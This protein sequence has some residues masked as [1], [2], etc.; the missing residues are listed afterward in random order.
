MFAFLS[1]SKE[2]LEF[3]AYIKLGNTLKTYLSI[4]KRG[5]GMQEH[6]DSYRIKLKRHV[7]KNVLNLKKTGTR[8]HD[9]LH[10]TCSDLCP[11]AEFNYG[12]LFEAYDPPGKPQGAK[13]I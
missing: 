6:L 3:E 4:F 12:L 13:T 10:I 7:E 8:G 11:S 5:G 9:F 1:M 2:I